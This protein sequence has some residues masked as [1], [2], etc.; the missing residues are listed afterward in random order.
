MVLI[1]SS[2]AREERKI[3]DGC[4]KEVTKGLFDAREKL[5]KELLEAIEEEKRTQTTSEK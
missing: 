1:L 3:R 2:I 5:L 4:R